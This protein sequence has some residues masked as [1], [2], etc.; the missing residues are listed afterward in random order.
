MLKKQTAA[1]NN[2]KTNFSSVELE[3]SHL[4]V[5]SYTE[6]YI[7]IITFWRKLKFDKNSHYIF[8]TQKCICSCRSTPYNLFN[9]T[10]WF[11]EHPEV[12]KVGGSSNSLSLVFSYQ[13]TNI[14]PSCFLVQYLLSDMV[15][16]KGCVKKKERWQG[17]E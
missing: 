5:Y 12:I 6:L 11:Q 17:L 10:L 14:D 8:Y 13:S 3:R 7:D 9:L 4:L 2:L 16:N 1:E 15:C